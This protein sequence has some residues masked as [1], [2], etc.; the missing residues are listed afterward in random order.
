MLGKNGGS[1][2]ID[3]EVMTT[4][5]HQCTQL[6]NTRLSKVLAKHKCSINHIGS[7]GA[8]ESEGA[9]TIFKQSKEL[10]GIQYAK[11]L[12]GGDSKALKTVTEAQ[13]YDLKIEKLECTG[14]IQKRMGKALLNLTSDNKTLRFIADSDGKE[15]NKLVANKSR[16]EKMYI[17]IGGTGRLTAKSIKSIQGHYGAVVRGNDCFVYEGSHL[18]YLQP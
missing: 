3:T 9:L 17:G 8:M 7:A 11:Y 14:H 1:K 4:F 13:L 18:A 6:E 12:G 2:V 15:L 5:C 16:S 10:Y